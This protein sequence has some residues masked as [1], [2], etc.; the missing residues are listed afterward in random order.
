MNS[1]IEPYSY[2]G[3][4][5]PFQN[6]SDIWF[7]LKQNLSSLMHQMPSSIKKKLKKIDYGSIK[8]GKRENYVDSLPPQSL[9]L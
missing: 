2:D 9:Q 7:P 8:C 1:N 4:Y 5:E 6:H 3:G